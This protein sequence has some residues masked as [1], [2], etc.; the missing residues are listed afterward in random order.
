MAQGSFESRRQRSKNSTGFNFYGILA[1]ES[2]AIVLC[3]AVSH[4][5]DIVT[6][7]D[8]HCILLLSSAL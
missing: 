2:Y 6:K 4:L 7:S 3:S 5:Q 1:K 8:C